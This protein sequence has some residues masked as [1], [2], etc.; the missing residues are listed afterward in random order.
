MSNNM[1]LIWNGN[2]AIKD[3]LKLNERFHRTS[4]SM[5]LNSLHTCISQNHTC[6]CLPMLTMVKLSSLWWLPNML[7]FIYSQT[8][9]IGVACILK[10]SFV[11]ERFTLLY[12]EKIEGDNSSHFYCDSKAS[13]SIWSTRCCH[14]WSKWNNKY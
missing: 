7:M 11:L 14:I 5:F 3:H 13:I 2:K 10:M 12:I 1:T 8:N 4:T 9:K 6:K